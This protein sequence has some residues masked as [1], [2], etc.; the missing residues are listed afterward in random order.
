MLFQVVVLRFGRCGDPMVAK[1]DK[2]VSRRHPALRAAPRSRHD[3]AATRFPPQL[4]ACAP[5]LQRMAA[6]FT[7][8]VDEVPE[9]ARY[10]DV[11]LTPS[12]VF[13][14]NAV[15]MKMDSGCVRAGWK[16]MGPMC[17]ARRLGRDAVF[18]RRTP[19][20][21]K[22][23]GVFAE[24]QDLIDVVE[25]RVSHC[26]RHWACSLRGRAPSSPRPARL[27][28]TDHLPRRLARQAHCA[29]PATA[30]AHSAL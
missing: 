14:F 13:F 15:H 3:R 12:C 26:P 6:M 20:H 28:R 10:F 4:E 16:E 29:V 24:K 25:V 30:R 19:D 21:S 22:F 27:R 8:D 18:G 11:T 17:A 7:V 5:A 1:L 2:I 9:Y 23:V